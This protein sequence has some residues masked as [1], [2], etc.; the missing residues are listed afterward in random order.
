[1]LVRNGIRR[2]VG[3]TVHPIYTKHWLGALPHCLC[4][5][6][7][8]T[9]AA[10]PWGDP[11]VRHPPPQPAQLDFADVVRDVPALEALAHPEQW[12]WWPVPGKYSLAAY[13]G[14]REN[15]GHLTTLYLYS[16][17]DAGAVRVDNTGSKPKTVW[18]VRGDVHTVLN[19]LTNRVYTESTS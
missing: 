15:R 17:R 10:R 11:R 5:L 7:H 4:Y 16:E 6:A 1:V 18:N 19:E 2:R 13:V 9:S 14:V 8:R 12:R 3:S